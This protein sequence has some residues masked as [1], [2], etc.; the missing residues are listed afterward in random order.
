MK[1]IVF[2]LLV[3]LLLSG[4]VFS[5]SRNARVK[6]A[7]GTVFSTNGGNG[8]GE[9]CLKIKGKVQCFEWAKSVTKFYGFNNLPQK[10]W[11]RTWDKGT[12]W[13]ITYSNNKTTG[14]SFLETVTLIRLNR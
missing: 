12:Q 14:E 1:H 13:R 2:C 4:I 5:Q 6:S 9:V 11:E 3:L 7:V 10:D 8:S